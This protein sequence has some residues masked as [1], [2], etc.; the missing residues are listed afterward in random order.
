[1]QK[2]YFNLYEIVLRYTVLVNK[3]FLLKWMKITSQNPSKIPSPNRAKS[4]FTG[5]IGSISLRLSS[6]AVSARASF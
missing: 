2:I 1:M 4:Y 5:S 6:R 3:F